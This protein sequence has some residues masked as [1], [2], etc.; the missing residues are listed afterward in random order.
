MQIHIQ[1]DPT[2]EEE[3]DRLFYCTVIDG[4]RHGFLLGP[5]ETL[6]GAEA[7]VKRARILAH[8]IDPNT[9]WYGIGAAGILRSNPQ[10][11]R[12]LFADQT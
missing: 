4:D 6:A 9:V 3:T 12:V 10:P 2:P 7:N 1:P 8:S 5:Y 11:T